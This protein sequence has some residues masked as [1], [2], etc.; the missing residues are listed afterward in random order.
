MSFA[1][2]VLIGGGFTAFRERV[3]VRRCESVHKLGVRHLEQVK[4]RGGRR[5]ENREGTRNIC[6]ERQRARLARRRKKGGLNSRRCDS[7]Q[8]LTANRYEELGNYRRARELTMLPTVEVHAGCEA[9]RL[10]VAR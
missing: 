7:A 6:R 3:A 10:A 4:R 5:E 9:R 1:C 2:S 8:P